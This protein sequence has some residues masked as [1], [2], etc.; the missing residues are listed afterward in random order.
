MRSSNK[1]VI[2]VPSWEELAGRLHG[3]SGLKFEDE[4]NVDGFQTRGGWAS[5]W[6]CSDSTATDRLNRL[7]SAGMAETVIG[8]RDGHPT[9]FY[10]VKA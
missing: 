3:L 5:D 1:T 8:L 9:K 2:E 10:K 4:L 7:V 6:N